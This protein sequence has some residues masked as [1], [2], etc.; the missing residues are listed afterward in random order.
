MSRS[1][2]WEG[3]YVAMSVALGGVAAEAAASLE[4]EPAERAR[5]LVDAMTRSSREARARMIAAGLA[6]I[7]IAVE[8]ARLG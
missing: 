5:A 2:G 7:A 1:S 8:K 3:A 6:R 4:G